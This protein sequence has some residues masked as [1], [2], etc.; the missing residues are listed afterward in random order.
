[1]A[2]RQQE[3]GASDAPP[4]AIEIHAASTPAMPMVDEVAALRESVSALA[5][6]L[7][8]REAEITDLISR[9]ARSEAE[10]ERLRALTAPV[11]P[12][13]PP[14]GRTVAL[15]EYERGRVYER[16]AT[17]VAGEVGGV[18]TLRV[19]GDRS[20]RTVDA[21]PHD[22]SQGVVDR[23]GYVEVTAYGDA[24]AEARAAAPGLL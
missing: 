20:G 18:L 5:E 22:A 4:P 13:S 8:A 19:Q 6:R 3:S 16:T 11:M 24:L 7:A 12:A 15:V 17:V 10:C 21:A 14:P 1:M 9:L 23:V 2:K